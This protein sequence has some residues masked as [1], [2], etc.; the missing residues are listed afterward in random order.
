MGATLNFW[1]SKAKQSRRISLP[2]LCDNRTP[3]TG[4]QLTPRMK[5]DRRVLYDFTFDAPKSVTLAHELGQDK[6]RARRIRAGRK[7][8]R[9]VRWKARS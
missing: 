5:A 9:W 3:E 6:T 4:E 7:A 1:A 2:S 8:K